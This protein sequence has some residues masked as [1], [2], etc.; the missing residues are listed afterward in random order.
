MIHVSNFEDFNKISEFGK[1]QR[2]IEQRKA[3][4]QRQKDEIGYRRKSISFWPCCM[5]GPAAWLIL[6]F[7]MKE[8]TKLNLCRQWLPMKRVKRLDG[9]N[10]GR[11]YAKDSSEWTSMV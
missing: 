2:A 6:V 8:E 10:L 7:S 4:N 11:D 1:K 5:A 3:Q 9:A